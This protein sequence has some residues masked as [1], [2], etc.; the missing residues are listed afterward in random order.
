VGAGNKVREFGMGRES[1]GRGKRKIILTPEERKFRAEGRIC[2]PYPVTGRD[3]E[4][5]GE[6]R[7]R[8]TLVYKICRSES[9]HWELTF[10]PLQEQVLLTSEPSLQPKLIFFFLDRNSALVTH[11]LL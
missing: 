4:M 8:S 7:G 3:R 2:Q 1:E 10:C 6:P 9:Q 5:L 11:W